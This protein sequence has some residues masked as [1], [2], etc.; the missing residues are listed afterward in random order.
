MNTSAARIIWLRRPPVLIDTSS[1]F[2]PGCTEGEIADAWDTLK[3]ANPRL[4]D[5]ACWHVVAVSRNGYGGASIHVGRTTYRMGA[6]RR[7]VA[8]GF[9]GLGVKAV[10]HWNGLVLL[11]RRSEACASYP[12]CWEFA[13]GGSAEPGEDP[14]DS[15]AR[16]LVEE[17]GIPVAKP[18]RAVAML[19]DPLVRNWEI[20]HE[21]A[22][23]HPPEHPPNWEYS[24]LS[25][26]R[27]EALP[28]P[29][30]EVTQTMA[31]MSEIARRVLSR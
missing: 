6:V 4:V 7:V 27:L 21:I 15:I 13:P 3:S 30:S 11:G 23:S 12:G 1:A 28:E 17:C 31:N 29:T 22:L 18:P 8:T 20:V 5:G 25:L 10:S 9:I 19:F 24:E 16:E 2:V 14:R 26:A